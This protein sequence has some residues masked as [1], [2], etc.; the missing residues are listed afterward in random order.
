MESLDE[1]ARVRGM[2][3]DVLAAI[4]PHLTLYGPQ[5]PDLTAADPIVAAALDFVRARRASFQANPPRAQAGSAKIARITATAYG[6]NNAEVTRAAVVRL[7]PATPQGSAML[8]WGA[9]LE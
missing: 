1:L 3:P 8:A 5:E 2:T 9:S 6:P 7:D 4:R